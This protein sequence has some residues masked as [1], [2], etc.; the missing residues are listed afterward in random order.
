M[1]FRSATFNQFG[2]IDVEINHPKFGWIPFTAS[3]DDPEK[4]GRDIYTAAMT[5]PVASYVAS[6][7]VVIDLDQLD[8]STINAALTQ[9]GS[10]VRALGLVMFDEINKLRVKTGD[11]A[12]TM[13]Q[14][15]AVLKVRMRA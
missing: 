8:I 9:D 4:L 10:I 2:T 12:Y 7:A 5:G 11:P 15:R 13:A 3:P 14:F 1:E 6:P